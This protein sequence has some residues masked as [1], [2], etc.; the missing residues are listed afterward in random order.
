[1]RPL[2]II[3]VLATLLPMPGHAMRV[4][5]ADDVPYTLTAHYLNDSWSITL[6]PHGT[7]T[8]PMSGIVL[9]F[10]SQPPRRTLSNEEY[11]IQD[12]VMTLNRRNCCGRN[13]K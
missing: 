6:P 9:E 11:M 5:N 12:G 4:R 2:C 3:A 13:R 8:R 10:S 1:M 7:Y